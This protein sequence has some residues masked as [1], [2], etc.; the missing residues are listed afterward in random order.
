MILPR[1]AAKCSH[2]Q[3]PFRVAIAVAICTFVVASCHSPQAPQLSV[4]GHKA[5]TPAS[6]RTQSSARLAHSPF[7]AKPAGTAAVTA[8]ANNYKELL[9]RYPQSKQKQIEGWYAK[10]A[11]GS[12]TFTSN[13]QWQWMR[14]HDYP[15]P[16]DVLRAL[17]MSESE[18][19]ELAMQGDTKANFFYL[20][21]LLHDYAQA[22]KISNTP[23]LHTA[24]LRE[25]INA[26]MHRA[27]ASGSAFAGYLFGGYYATLHGE[28][29]IG[30]G[31]AAG[32]T[33]VDSFGDGRPVYRF[34]MA[35]GFPGASGARVAEV[36]FDMFAAAARRK[37]YF[38]NEFRGRS[39]PLI[40]LR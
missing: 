34:P 24:G 8:G 40:P 11:N 9:K 26:S 13:E 35:A 39:T 38:L 6:T 37:P 25:K 2:S 32:L 29:K 10:H 7:A 21:R 16:D 19:R 31:R 28:G 15:T 33:W 36:Y 20:V 18:L 1:Q 30:I 23:T 5:A 12:M 17:S 14:Q 22:N 4:T 27:L 3:A